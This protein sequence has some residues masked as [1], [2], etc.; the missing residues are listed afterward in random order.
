MSATLAVKFQADASYGPGTPVIFGGNNE[1]TTASGQAQTTAIAGVV[2]DTAEQVLNADLTGSNVVLVAVAGRIQIEVDVPV[3]Q[4][5]LIMIGASGRGVSATN[6]ANNIPGWS[7]STG[8][9]IGRA[10]E[11]STVDSGS[12]LIEILLASS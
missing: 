3:V 8:S 11:S 4:G 5:D 7:M 12:Q 9:I 6:L 2:T 1:V 10:I